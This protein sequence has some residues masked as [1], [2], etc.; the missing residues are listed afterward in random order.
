MYFINFHDLLVAILQH[1]FVTH[2]HKQCPGRIWPDP[3]RFV[4]NLPTKS[5]I[6]NSGLWIPG[7]ERNFYRSIT[8]LFYPYLTTRNNTDPSGSATL[9]TFLGLPKK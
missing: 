1:F 8:W 3:V 4:L 7:Y 9:L 6:R 5:G 2:E